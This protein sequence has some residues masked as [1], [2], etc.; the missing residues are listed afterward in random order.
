MFRSGKDLFSIATQT[1]GTAF[2]VRIMGF[3][4]ELVGLCGAGKTTFITALSQAMS[5]GDGIIL[6]KPVIP[7]RATYLKYIIK[8]LCLAWFSY[9]LGLAKF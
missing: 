7:D 1:Y 5:I 2:L 6:E 8:I 9:P 3:R 4:I